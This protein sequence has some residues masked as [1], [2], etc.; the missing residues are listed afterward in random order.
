M[1]S[2]EKQAKYYGK[3][4][5]P[6]FVNLR[7]P[8]LRKVELGASLVTPF[9]D[10]GLAF[11]GDAIVTNGENYVVGTADEY[12]VKLANGRNTTF[13]INNPDIRYSDGGKIFWGSVG[14]GILPI[15]K[16]TGRILLNYRS[17]YVLEPNTW[18]V[19]GGKLDDEPVNEQGIIDA[20]KRELLEE[21][22][23]D[24]EIE[25]IPSFVFRHKKQFTYHNFIGLVEDEFI[26][27]M[28]WESDGYKWV[29][30]QELLDIQPKHF[31]LKELI[32]NDLK[33]IERLTKKSKNG[34]SK[35][36]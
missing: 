36:Q 19:Y 35:Y 26:P 6:L 3:I 8:E 27:E 10:E 11:E 2:D 9:D 16:K 34:R 4:T 33:T 12:A 24:K 28:D 13:D 1:T 31:G 25:I 5:I 20:A 23:Y 18:G 30:L 21:T 17:S 22:G 29:T 14:A 15:C 7:Y 32:K